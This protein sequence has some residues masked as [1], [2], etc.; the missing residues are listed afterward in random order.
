MKVGV[1]AANG[2][3]GRLIVENALQQ[4]LDV[5]AIVR[6]D[7]QTQA[8]N[9]LQKDL[10][11]LTKE[12]VASFDVLIDAFGVW[13]PNRFH[14]HTDS[15]KHLCDILKG[16]QTRLMVVGGAGSLYMNP[17][18]TLQLKDTPDF[19]KEFYGLANAMSQSLDF[20]RTQKTVN[21]TYVS[22]AA[23]FQA[24]GKKTGQYTIAGEEFAVN[25]AGQ[26]YISYAD[27]ATA[28][29]D[30]LRHQPR[31]QERVLVFCNV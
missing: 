6:H 16:S 25:S 23:D 4:Q 3:V 7:N 2:K 20:L 5:Y 26:S 24:D 19:P 13:D 30:I 28:F 1:I 15:L 31:R 18:H 14:L 12:D 11:A 21:W 22:P 29:V 27:Y 10:F 9:V 8:K 17:D